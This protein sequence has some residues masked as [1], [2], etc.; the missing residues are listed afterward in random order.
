MEITKAIRK[1]NKLQD[2]CLRE[3]ER[4]E[5]EDNFITPKDFTTIPND[6]VDKYMEL[7]NHEQ[8]KA[9]IDLIK[10]SYKAGFENGK[11]DMYDE[12]TQ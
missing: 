8:L 1:I 9:V 10:Q 11:T 2:K 3:E 5:E 6:L 7:F 4:K 12:M